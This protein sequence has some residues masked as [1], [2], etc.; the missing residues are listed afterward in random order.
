MNAQ[1]YGMRKTEIWIHENF[2]FFGENYVKV[3]Y[4]KNE[5]KV[6]KRLILP[7]RK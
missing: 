1:E 5:V 2:M 3:W 6:G 7:V 4:A